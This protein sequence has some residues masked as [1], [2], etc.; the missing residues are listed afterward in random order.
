M[1]KLLTAL[2]ILTLVS[3]GAVPIA[4]AGEPGINN[5]EGIDLYVI[6]GVDWD[7][8]AEKGDWTVYGPKWN[9]VIGG[10][11]LSSCTNC[12]EMVYDFT[13]RGP[14]VHFDELYVDTVVATPQS[15]HVVLSDLDG[16]GTYTG[17][18]PA[19]HYF[20]WAAEPDGSW[21][22]T[23]F[24]RIEYTL[25]FDADGNLLDFHYYQFEHK[26]LD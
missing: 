13:F 7:G 18:L 25:T 23:Y 16:D 4:G 24:D 15:K 1:R 20:P 21:A 8:V 12:L 6:I 19:A 2:A 5:P 10:P 11:V 3:L 22:V 26:K 9:P 17:S 14:T